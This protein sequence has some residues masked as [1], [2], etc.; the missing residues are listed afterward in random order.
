M[1]KLLKGKN[2]VALI[3]IGLIIIFL[4]M[5]INIKRNGEV[6]TY[7]ITNQFLLKTPLGFAGLRPS[8]SNIIVRSL[9]DYRYD[10]QPKKLMFNP[11]DKEYWV[12][13]VEFLL[14][15]DDPKKGLNSSVVM[16]D[17]GELGE[18]D[19]ENKIHVKIERLY[20]ESTKPFPKKEDFKKSDLDAKFLKHLSDEIFMDCFAVPYSSDSSAFRIV[21]CVGEVENA[22]I[23]MVH[24]KFYEYSFQRDFF[25]AHANLNRAFQF[26]LESL[27]INVTFYVTGE[28]MKHWKEISQRI[29]ELI[30]IWNV[31]PNGQVV[32]E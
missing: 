18:F 11:K 30:E 8:P 4:M 9:G 31:E 29:Y 24:L 16:A 26:R 22:N 28:N 19:S 27:G 13:T 6:V 12:N 23:P 14:V 2:K 25:H 3:A 7:R 20:P 17:Q 15:V 1:F 32:R 21:D 5:G 10:Y